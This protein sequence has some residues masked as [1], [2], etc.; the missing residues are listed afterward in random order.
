MKVYWAPLDNK[1]LNLNLAYY[2]PGRLS[3]N[4]PTDLKDS[5]YYRCPAFLETVRNTFVLKSPINIQFRVN[6][7]RQQ[8]EA[9]DNA[10]FG[11]KIRF[12]DALDHRIAQFGFNYL[13]FA[14]RP[15]K[16]TQIHPYLHHN[17]FTDNGNA[18]LGEFDCGQWLRPLQAAFVLDPSKQEYNYNIKR[19]DVY[20][21]IKFDTDEKIEMVRFD[22]TPAIEDIADSCLQMK[23]AGNGRPFSLDKCYN[24]FIIHKRRKAILTEI[25]RQGN[26]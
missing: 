5:G 22:A 19:G 16:F 26:L 25:K 14:E 12:D 2:E 8:A 7:S 20:S 11:L 3:N 6:P 13:M 10:L 18:L 23:Q 9:N 24:Q 15:L 1:E 17:S 4:I 21:Y